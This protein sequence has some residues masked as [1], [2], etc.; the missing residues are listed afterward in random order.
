MGSADLQTKGCLVRA[1]S[2]GTRVTR[3]AAAASARLMLI[4]LHLNSVLHPTMYVKFTLEP[5]PSQAGVT[6]VRT[7]RTVG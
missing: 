7:K 2:T 1:T 4:A 6:P 5:L 3:N